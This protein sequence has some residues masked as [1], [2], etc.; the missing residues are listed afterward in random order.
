MKTNKH[1][2]RLA[3]TKFYN[4]ILVSVPHESVW[5]KLFDAKITGCDFWR[6]PGT[7]LYPKAQMQYSNNNK[8]GREA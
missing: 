4:E 2:Y 8:K 3:W 7:D 1:W 5:G 6:K